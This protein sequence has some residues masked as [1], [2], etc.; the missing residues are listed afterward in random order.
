MI[1]TSIKICFVLFLLL[2]ISVVA[3]K[4]FVYFRPSDLTF[5]SD[6]HYTNVHY[7]H[8][9]GLLVSNDKKK[10]ILILPDIKDNM[11]FYH[12]RMK[13]FQD[14]N[15]DCAIYNYSGFG[16]TS[17]VPSED[18]L[19]R[20]CKEMVISL[21]SSYSIENMILYGKGAGAFCAIMT[22]IDFGISKIILDEPIRCIKDRLPSFMPKFIFNEF[23]VE[24]NIYFYKGQ[25]LSNSNIEFITDTTID[26]TDNINENSVK[27]FIED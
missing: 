15:Y 1:I 11:T 23:D 3:I 12:N 18:K 14:M 7:K 5:V 4:R 8:L 9:S 10:I 17:G 2:Y 22:A 21:L 27:K 13:M 6:E 16:T 19:L 24:K 26:Y 20:D 25:I